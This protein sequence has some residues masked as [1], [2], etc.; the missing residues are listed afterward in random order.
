MYKLFLAFI[1]L[2]FFVSCSQK[3]EDHNTYEPL[4]DFCSSIHRDTSIKLSRKLDSLSTLMNTKTGVYVLEDGDG[5]MVAR[6]W[7]SEYAEKSIDI[8]YFIFTADN[9]GLIAADY[10]V[11]AADR[12]VKVRILVDDVMVEAD[13][14]KL[15]ILDSHKNI[16]IKIYNPSTNVGKNLSNK[17]YN[18]THDFRGA[19]QRMHNKTFI[20]DGKVVITG[21][22]N[23]A[24]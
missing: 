9:V 13:D 6:A 14:E 19:N 5:S 24:D 23:I 2:S 11:R 12:G 17:V 3:T 20:V 7:L 4:T 18:L 15:L 1:F 16:S 22:R 8:Q 21:G 10:L